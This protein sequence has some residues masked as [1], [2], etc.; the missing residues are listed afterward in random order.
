MKVLLLGATG[1]SVSEEE[2]GAHTLSQDVLQGLLRTSETC[3]HEF[4]L[5]EE[6]PETANRTRL[7]AN[8]TRIS[9]KRTLK[10]RVLGR[11]EQMAHRISPRLTGLRNGSLDPYLRDWEA[12]LR[13][14]GVDCALAL[15]PFHISPV[16]PNIVTVW[17]VE[18]R[19]KP[20][21]PEVSEYGEWERR[22]R[23]FRKVL[24]PALMVITGT[25]EG[26][27]Q[28]QRFYG[29]D[30]ENVRVIPFPTPS[31]A[32]AHAWEDISRADLP[33]CVEG[34]YLFYPAQYW[35][36]KNHI[37]L[38]QAVRIL[39]DRY[40]W[41]GML[42]CCGSDKGN[43]G[44]L[45]DQAKALLISD[46]VQFLGFVGR[47]ELIALYRNAL[48]MPFLSYFGPDNLPPLEA[49]ALGCPVIAAAIDGAADAYGGAAHYVN[50]DDA[51][52]TAEAIWRLRSDKQSRLKLVEA[53]LS[54]AGHSTVETYVNRLLALLD[55][56]EVRFQC[57]R[58]GKIITLVQGLMLTVT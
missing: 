34:E 56:L 35:S 27:R 32:L 53:G 5:P 13:A 39:R 58:A 55:E 33:S 41:T 43:L 26:K 14:Q 45:K 11:L 28:I 36:H 57:F 18:H 47:R 48:A 2:G 46:Q 15:H 20:L 12:E 29:V 17:D 3:A 54:K 49:F 31:F 7:P 52:V 44:H 24:P 30:A 50:P 25:E 23:H 16:L 6:L 38:L 10:H 40:G 21:F 9:L 51:A 8:F 19:R 1:S 4:C 22:D 42:V 37:R